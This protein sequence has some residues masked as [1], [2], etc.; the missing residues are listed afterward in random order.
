MDE[1]TA[2]PPKCNEYTK[3]MEIFDEVNAEVDK[4]RLEIFGE[5]EG[6]NLDAAYNPMDTLDVMKIYEERFTM[7]KRTRNIFKIRKDELVFFLKLQH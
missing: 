3:D 2:L 1:V 5:Y 6:E 7:A 4:M